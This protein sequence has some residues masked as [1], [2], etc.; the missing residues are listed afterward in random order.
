MVAQIP[1]DAVTNEMA[2]N[3]ILAFAR[4]GR[5]KQSNWHDRGADGQEIA[6][7]LGAIHPDI[8]S[9]TA[10]P[11]AL[12]PRWLANL[13]VRLFDGVPTDRVTHYGEAYAQRINRWGVFDVAAWER[14]RVA[15]ISKALGDAIARAESRSGVN[16][17]SSWAPAKAVVDKLMALLLSTTSTRDDYRALYREAAEARTLAW[18]VYNKAVATLRAARRAA[19]GTAA[20]EA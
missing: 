18:A 10:C 8:N 5:L 9:T 12:M 7:L 15:F 6:C 1:L 20:A 19:A 16:P 2:A 4:E 17:P 14:V 3:N 11:A 13:T